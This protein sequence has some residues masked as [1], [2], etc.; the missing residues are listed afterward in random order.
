MKMRRLLPLALAIVTFLGFES[1]LLRPKAVFFVAPV[2]LFLSFF[3]VQTILGR[4][5][6]TPASRLN[7]WIS[8]AIFYVVNFGLIFLLESV[9]FRHLLALGGAILV[10]LFLEGVYTY[11]WEHDWYEAYSLENISS[12]INSLSAFAL[13]GVSLGFMTFLQ[14]PVW[15]I[16]ILPFLFY[17][18]LSWQSFWIAKIPPRAGFI[19]A[20]AATLIILEI[21]LTLSLLPLHFLTAGAVLAIF[22]YTLISLFRAYLLGFWSRGVVLRYLTAIIILIGALLST[23]RWS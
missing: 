20:G 6:K 11:I 14:I 5:L 18:L 16:F 21:F 7:F 12:Y 23:A 13:G 19:Y 9:A 17:F 10:G 15:L 8:P 4:G 3:A 2:L 1:A 22:W